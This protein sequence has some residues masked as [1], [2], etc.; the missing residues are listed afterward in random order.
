[1]L[2]KYHGFDLSNL[3]IADTKKIEY[4]SN[5]VR[6]GLGLHIF[7]CAFKVKQMVLR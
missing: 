1:M 7:N 2:Q 4:L 5:C 3:E 6:P